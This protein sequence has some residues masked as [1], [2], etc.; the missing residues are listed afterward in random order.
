MKILD[1]GCGKAKKSNAL[2]IDINPDTDADVIHDL[3]VF[4][5]PFPDNEF[6][7]VHCDSILEHLDN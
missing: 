4:P 7:V 1:L 2:G 5:Y 6:G 3:N